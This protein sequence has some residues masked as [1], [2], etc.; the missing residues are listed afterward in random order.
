M[1]N[2]F[3]KLILMSSLTLLMFTS[4]CDAHDIAIGT[5]AVLPI[6]LIGPLTG[7][8]KLIFGD[9][10]VDAFVY[11]KNEQSIQ[12]FQDEQ[13]TDMGGV[14]F[15]GFD[16]GDISPS[17]DYAVL[18]LVRQGILD[19]PGEN[20]RVQGREYCPVVELHTGCVI[21]MPTGEVCGG[22]WSTTHD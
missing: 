20:S 10:W 13:L 7:K 18:P 17:G 6:R 15:E 8:N 3:W 9:G 11:T 5:D 14:V 19:M 2:I 12:L 21:S 22:K 4:P 1:V 16:Q